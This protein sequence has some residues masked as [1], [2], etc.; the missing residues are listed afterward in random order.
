M[1]C[2]RLCYHQIQYYCFVDED[3]L[4]GIDGYCLYSPGGDSSHQTIEALKHRVEHQ[5][6]I[7]I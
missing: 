7:S 1:T 5:I 2:P 4:F 6:E 3:V